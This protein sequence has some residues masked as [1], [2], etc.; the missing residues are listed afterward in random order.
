MII[1][2]IPTHPEF[3]E[4]SSYDALFQ[5]ARQVV[6]HCDVLKELIEKEI[7][8]FNYQR[9]LKKSQSQLSQ[10]RRSSGEDLENSTTPTTSTA[11]AVDINSQNIN[12]LNDQHELDTN[13][14][15]I[16]NE[17]ESVQFKRN[18][19]DLSTNTGP[20][21]FTN[22]AQTKGPVVANGV[23][24]APVSK[25]PSLNFNQVPNLNTERQNNVP[26]NETIKSESQSTSTIPI[27]A[28]KIQL[29]Q[30]YNQPLEQEYEYVPYDDSDAESDAVSSIAV[31]DYPTIADEPSLI[32]MYKPSN[33]TVRGPE[34]PPQVAISES[35]SYQQQ[36]QQQQQPQQHNPASFANNNGPR[37]MTLTPKLAPQ[38]EFVNSPISISSPQRP[39]KIK[40]VEQI[41]SLHESSEGR[42]SNDD[43]KEKSSSNFETNN[44]NANNANGTTF[45][46]AIDT[47]DPTLNPSSHLVH[48]VESYTEGGIPLKTVFVP[49]EIQSRFTSIAAPNTEKDLET[50]GILCGKLVNNAFFITDL[51]I[52][53]QNSTPNTCQTSNEELLLQFVDDN[54]LFILG[55]IHTHPT[56]SCFLSSVDL[57]TQN[58][59]QIMLPESIAIVVAPKSNPNFGIFRLSDPYGINLI[60]NCARRGFHPHSEDGL[61]DICSR[62]N[63][64]HVVVKRNLPLEVTDIRT[65]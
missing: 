13:G 37:E 33:S 19:S 42:S 3:Q 48:K 44:N 15:T 61:Y 59:Y 50:C 16:L 39:P 12:N 46:S 29:H 23:N 11:T 25:Y 32:K 64:G 45:Y 31:P 18:F 53:D 21:L 4:R 2:K 47:T 22:N 60:T 54:D 6:K 34:L 58:G 38:P 55:W 65:K 35:I 63:G 56:Q 49:V 28:P 62:T 17:N 26:N 14:D 5:K 40:S 20:S 43:L 52:P 1:N 7:E 51:V 36:Q 8:E 10:E 30:V 9:N 27:N 24:A 57:H 41:R